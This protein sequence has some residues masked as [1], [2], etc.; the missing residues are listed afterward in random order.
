[1][2]VWMKCEIFCPFLTGFQS[3]Q[4]DGRVIMK[5]NLVTVRKI[6]ASSGSRTAWSEGQQLTYW[7]NGAP[8]WSS[9]MFDLHILSGEN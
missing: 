6:S 7:A 3:Y 8:P 2:K 4:E 1:M 5:K 9:S